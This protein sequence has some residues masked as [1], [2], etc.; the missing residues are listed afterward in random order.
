MGAQLCDHNIDHCQNY[1][2]VHFEQ[3]NGTCELYLNNALKIN[4]SGVQNQDYNKIPIT[5]KLRVN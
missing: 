5:S 3:V 1:C 2:I 4:I